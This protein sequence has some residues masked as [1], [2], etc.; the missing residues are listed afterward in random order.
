MDSALRT[1]VESWI[2]DDPDP[3][4]AR[5]LTELLSAGDEV[6]QIGRAHV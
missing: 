2:A 5:R 3:I 1:E 6:T 4:T